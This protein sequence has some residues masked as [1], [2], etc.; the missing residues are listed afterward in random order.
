M[1]K[2]LDCSVFLHVKY[3]W[4]EVQFSPFTE[5]DSDKIHRPAQGQ[6]YI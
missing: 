3:K 2:S 6:K 4:N 5:I 1:E